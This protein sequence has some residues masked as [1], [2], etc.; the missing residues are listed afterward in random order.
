MKAWYFVRLACQLNTLAVRS[1]LKLCRG[2]INL[3]ALVH[4]ST[5]ETV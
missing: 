3:D 4:V 2:I 1:I 5:G